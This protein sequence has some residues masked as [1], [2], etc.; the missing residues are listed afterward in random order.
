MLAP[1]LHLVETG[2]I[3]AINFLT[4]IV[5]TCPENQLLPN[6]VY[7]ISGHNFPFRNPWSVIAI[8]IFPPTKYD[9]QANA[10]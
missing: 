1:S 9:S 10:I 4:K 3:P 7:M 6:L 2:T 5:L 8:K